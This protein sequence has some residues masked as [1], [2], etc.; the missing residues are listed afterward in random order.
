MLHCIGMG[1]LTKN[2]SKFVLQ[3][4]NFLSPAVCPASLGYTSADTFYNYPGDS[5][6]FM[7]S[8]WSGNW[9]R[10]GDVWTGMLNYF[11]HRDRLCWHY[12][13]YIYLNHIIIVAIPSAS[14]NWM[15]LYLSRLVC[16]V[17]MN[18]TGELSSIK[19]QC[20]DEHKGWPK[21]K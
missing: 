12:C 15:C 2:R 21:L 18:H 5:V 17:F 11:H 1:L 19:D 3:Q 4:W 8:C 16:Y 9:W 6:E 20:K 10:A 13:C 14:G 7:I